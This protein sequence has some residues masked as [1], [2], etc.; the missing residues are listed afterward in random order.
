M[1]KTKT[2]GAG[3]H[4]LKYPA[5]LKAECKDL[6]VNKRWAMKDIQE[7]YPQVTYD[8]LRS[9]VFTGEWRAERDALVKSEQQEIVMRRQHSLTILLGDSIEAISNTVKKYVKMGMTMEEAKDLSTV[10]SNMDKLARLADNKPTDITENRN[11]N[12]NIPAKAMV[13][14]ADIEDAIK[15]VQADPFTKAESSS[16]EQEQ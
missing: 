11:L 5:E 13:T 6:Y 7:K 14:K 2:S 4:N 1:P 9:W 8:A 12:V 16:D 15:I 3:A 10:I